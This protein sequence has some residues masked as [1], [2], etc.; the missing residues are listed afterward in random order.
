LPQ[1]VRFW[2]ASRQSVGQLEIGV[3]V[4]LVEAR[5][6]GQSVFAVV[7]SHGRDVAGWR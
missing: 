6:V 7:F 5:F 2:V 3:L 4:L 1:V